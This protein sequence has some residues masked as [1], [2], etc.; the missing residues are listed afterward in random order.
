MTK[1]ML[2]EADVQP[3][4][5]IEKDG[6]VGLLDY[7]LNPTPEGYKM[8]EGVVWP[9]WID[10][11]VR[12]WRIVGNDRKV[13]LSTFVERYYYYLN[14]I[15]KNNRIRVKQKAKY[16]E[17]LEKYMGLFPAAEF[18]TDFIHDHSTR[19][20]NGRAWIIKIKFSEKKNA[21]IKINKYSEVYLTRFEDGLDLTQKLELLESI[22]S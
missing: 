9:E 15:T 1:E 12:C 18:T 11:K 19:N 7:S 4:H 10:G 17:L 16:Q 2:L 13:K 14:D 6:R 20:A 21:V 3:N 22:Q 8:V 5:I